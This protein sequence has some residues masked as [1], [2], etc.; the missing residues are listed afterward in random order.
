MSESKQHWPTVACWPG[1]LPVA[2]FIGEYRSAT[3]MFMAAFRLFD[4]WSP[5][6][7]LT[8]VLLSVPCHTQEDPGIIKSWPEYRI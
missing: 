3:V 5:N 6:E 7:D 8:T 1:A 4:V 2:C